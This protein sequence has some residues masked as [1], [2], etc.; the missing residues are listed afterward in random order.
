MAKEAASD[1]N[2]WL[3]YFQSIRSVCPWF[4]PAYKK[5]QIDIKQFFEYQPLGEFL[6]RVYI[7]NIR[8][9]DLAD[10]MER[11][12]EWFPEEEWFWSHPDEGGHSAPYPCLIQQSHAHLQN[13]RKQSHQ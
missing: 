1:H 7:Y 2:T 11:L 3:E 13:I 12:N 10:M 9:A 8:P 6:A 4:F 5:N